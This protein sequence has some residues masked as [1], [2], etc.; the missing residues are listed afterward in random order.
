[1]KKIYA[2]LVVMVMASGCWAW[3]G[4]FGGA[5]LTPTGVSNLVNGM[6]VPKALVADSVRQDF[7]KIQIEISNSTMFVYSTTN[8]FDIVIS[9]TSSAYNGTAKGS[10]FTN[11]TY[12]ELDSKWHFS[13]GGD[14]LLLTAYGSDIRE[15][16]TW[17]LIPFAGDSAWSGT[18]QAAFDDSVVLSPDQSENMVSS[19]TVTIAWTQATKTT[20]GIT[21]NHTVQAGDVLQFEFGLLKAINP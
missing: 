15:G 19:G 5:T 8:C 1:M 16:G 7:G 11:A 9:Q 18:T 6:T 17:R 20:A 4:W 13:C 12:S 3:P 14:E 21:T 10:I 2:G